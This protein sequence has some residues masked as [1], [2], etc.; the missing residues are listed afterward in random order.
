MKWWFFW[1]KF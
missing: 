1:K